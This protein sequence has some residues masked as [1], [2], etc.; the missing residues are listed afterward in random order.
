M[1]GIKR[2][3]ERVV[4]NCKHCQ[5]QFTVANYRKHTALFCSRKCLA[6]SA[7]QE[8]TTACEIC[9]EVF[10]HIASRANKAKY[11]SR[12]CYHKA[13]SQKGTV[14]Y[15]CAHCG[16]KFLDA[17]SHKRKYCSRKCVNKAS[18]KVWNPDF[19]TVRKQMLC[20]GML[21]ACQRCGF[22]SHQQIL[23]VHHKDRNRNNNTLDNLEVLCP[24]C[25]SV[26][27]SR[28]ICHGFS[29]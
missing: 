6:L 14:E 21:T 3:R 22:S 1:S 15:T 8:V 13:Q 5:N 9:G 7:R 4:K 2:S 17:P 25:H 11:C 28:H 20:R 10:S 12:K 16:V 23:G 19:S 26:E 27:H 24:N 29:H 18:K